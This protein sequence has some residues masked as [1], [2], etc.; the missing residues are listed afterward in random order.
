MGRVIQDASDGGHG[1]V[2]LNTSGWCDTARRIEHGLNASDQDPVQLHAKC[3]GA[4][5]RPDFIS[6]DANGR[7]IER[8]ERPPWRCECPCHEGQEIEV[9]KPKPVVIAKAVKQVTAKPSGSRNAKLLVEIAETLRRDG[10]IEF[11]RPEDPKQNKSLRERIYTA[12]RKT[13]MPVRVKD[14]KAEGKI[15]AWRK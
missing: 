3:H 2:L 8:V 1:M 12:C 10:Y 11:P 5:A 6:K 13:G 4:V 9:Y 15:Q 7:T 14:N